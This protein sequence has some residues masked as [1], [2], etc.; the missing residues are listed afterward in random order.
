MKK[1]KTSR[2][3]S[4]SEIEKMNEKMRSRYETVAR[5]NHGKLN[6][7]V[8]IVK[9][10]KKFV[11]LSCL[12]KKPKKRPSYGR[13]FDHWDITCVVDDSP[14]PGNAF[15][16]MADVVKDVNKGVIVG[17]CNPFVEL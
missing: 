11:V 16:L 2:I 1:Q 17:Y 12:M 6:R 4:S 8:A 13:E 9:S 10:K 14:N 15:Q 7:T 3:P 5:W